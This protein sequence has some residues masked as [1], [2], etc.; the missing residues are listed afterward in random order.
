MKGN[1][2]VIAQLQKLLRSELVARDQYFIHARICRDGGYEKLYERLN[3][4]SEEEAQH[5]DALINRLLFLETVPEMKRPDAPNIGATIPDIF[6]NDLALEY[7]VIEEL[8]KAIKV[9]E[10]KQ[11]Y[12]TREILRAML[13]DTE[14]DHTWWLERQLGLIEAVGLENYLQSML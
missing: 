8:R 10:E 11:D 5:A 6:R 2:K 13:A 1:D 7:A 14:E 4:E 9:C 3:H 12:Q